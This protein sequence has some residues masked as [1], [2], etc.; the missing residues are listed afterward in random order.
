MN[1]NQNL[2]IYSRQTAE[3][4]IINICVLT[5]WEIYV[6]L[7]MIEEVPNER[8]SRGRTELSYN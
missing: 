1:W 6:Y 4:E 3:N 8:V 5:K 7:L 2:V